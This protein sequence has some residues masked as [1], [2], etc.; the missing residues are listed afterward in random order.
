MVSGAYVTQKCSIVIPIKHIKRSQIFARITLTKRKLHIWQG[1][2][3]PT[4]QR[5]FALR[6]IG[7]INIP[8]HQ[9]RGRSSQRMVANCMMITIIT[10]PHTLNSI[11]K[12]VTRACE[13]NGKWNTWRW[14]RRRQNSTPKMLA[15][16]NTMA[17]VGV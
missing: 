16:I 3:T 9:H 15:L 2:H 11:Y 12:D 10:L 14:N 6:H 4:T 5:S 8:V 13:S 17:L 7:Q 1:H